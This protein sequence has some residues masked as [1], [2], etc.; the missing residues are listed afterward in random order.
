MYMWD[1]I[2][3]SSVTGIEVWSCAWSKKRVKSC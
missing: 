1:R 2:F 3:E